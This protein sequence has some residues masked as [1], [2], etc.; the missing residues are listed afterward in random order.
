MTFSKKNEVTTDKM[1]VTIVEATKQE[2]IDVIK[3]VYSNDMVVGDSKHDDFVKVTVQI[4][5]GEKNKRHK[6]EFSFRLYRCGVDSIQ[7]LINY[8]D[9]L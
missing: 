4:L 2:V 9:E 6:D 8:I 1:A 5:S 3:S 7:K